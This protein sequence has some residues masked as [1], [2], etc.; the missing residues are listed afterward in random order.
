MISFF[1]LGFDILTEIWLCPDRSNFNVSNSCARSH[2]RLNSIW[3]SYLSIYAM[4]CV[5]VNHVWCRIFSL[6]KSTTFPRI[7]NLQTNYWR[8][9][10]KC[11]PCKEQIDRFSVHYRPHKIPAHDDSRLIFTES[12]SVSPSIGPVCLTRDANQP[13]NDPKC[14]ATQY[15]TLSIRWRGRGDRCSASDTSQWYLR[16]SGRDNKSVVSPVSTNNRGSIASVMDCCPIRFLSAVSKK[17]HRL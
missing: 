15:F 14:R 13:A 12:L 8:I 5:K 6:P 2:S 3:Q 9:T 10:A 17:L 16:R 1:F 11:L 4:L 7:Q